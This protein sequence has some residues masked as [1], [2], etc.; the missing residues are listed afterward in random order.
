MDNLTRKLMIR[1]K[2]NGSIREEQLIFNRPVKDSCGEWFCEWSIGF[3]HPR[4]KRI[5]GNDEIAAYYYALNFVGSFIRNMEDAGYYVW[6]KQEGDLGGFDF[7]FK[8]TNRRS[9]IKSKLQKESARNGNN[10]RPI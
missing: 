3:I 2:K 4:K 8:S 6:T 1:E 9:I 10:L 5:Y 7:A